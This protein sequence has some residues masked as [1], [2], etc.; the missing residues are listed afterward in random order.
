MRDD[1]GSFAVFT[2]QGFVCATG[3]SSISNGCH[4]KTIRVRSASRR[5]SICTHSGLNGRCSKIA[6]DSQIGMSRYLV[7]SATT[8]MPKSRASMVDPFV[9]LERN[10]YGHP[11]A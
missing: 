9:P 11:L 2:E 8:Q 6:E 5:C 7:S 1:S 3:D 4:S 10:L